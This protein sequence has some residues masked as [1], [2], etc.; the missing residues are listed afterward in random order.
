VDNKYLD[1]LHV[2]KDAAGEWRYHGQ[3]NNGEIL[4]ASEGYGE[5][6][7]A[8]EA[9]ARLGDQAEVPVHID[10]EDDD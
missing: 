5:R 3:S 7:D 4:F 2:F 10:G 6:G 8:I 1:T 9:A